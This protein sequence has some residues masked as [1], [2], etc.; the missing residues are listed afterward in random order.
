MY[1]CILTNVYHFYERNTLI[2]TNIVFTLNWNNLLCT[3]FN[4]K[5]KA[6]FKVQSQLRLINSL[7]QPGIILLISG[8]Q[9]KFQPTTLKLCPT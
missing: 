6:H 2:H 4:A 3:N 9:S 7:Y 5:L 1:L 8:P